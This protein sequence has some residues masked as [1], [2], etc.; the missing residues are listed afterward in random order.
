[1]LDLD[2]SASGAI[3]PVDGETFSKVGE[4]GS[5]VEV[6]DE[7]R[8]SGDDEQEVFDEA[9]ESAKEVDGLLLTISAGAIGF[10]SVEEG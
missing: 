7:R 1:L 5:E 10:G 4:F 3:Y 8:C 2:E 9:G 6:A